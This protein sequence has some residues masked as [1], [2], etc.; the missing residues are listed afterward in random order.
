MLFTVLT[1]LHREQ[2]QR[3]YSPQNIYQPSQKWDNCKAV[4]GMN[5]DTGNDVII[6]AF[7]G[8][9]R[10]NRRLEP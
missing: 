4:T 9:E 8:V 2:Q 10:H 7:S 5:S 1:C 6:R 3:G